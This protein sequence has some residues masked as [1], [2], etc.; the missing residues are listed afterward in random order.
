MQKRIDKEPDDKQPLNTTFFSLPTSSKASTKKTFTLDLKSIIEEK[1][2]S[3]WHGRVGAY[4]D[5]KFQLLSE[6]KFTGREKRIPFKTYFISLVEIINS[7]QR[8]KYQLMKNMVR[9]ISEVYGSVAISPIQHNEFCNELL[10]QIDI[11]M[12]ASTEKFNQLHSN[13]D[14]FVKKPPIDIISQYWI[15]LL[16]K[17]NP[18]QEQAKAYTTQLNQLIIWFEQVILAKEKS[19]QIMTHFNSR[20][21]ESEPCVPWYYIE[22]LFDSN[23]LDEHKLETFKKDYQ[24]TC[25]G[26]ASEFVYLPDMWEF[27]L[28]TNRHMINSSKDTLMEIDRILKKQTGLL[29]CKTQEQN[30]LITSIMGFI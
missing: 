18:E 20:T 10:F 14:R 16:S 30:K 23:K 27:V 11:A 21:F 8:T 29:E 17:F 24:Q 9:I 1:A 25:F 26:L 15:N 19:D 28:H 6:T 4:D 2:S 13:I 3:E 22:V 7:A 5:E 12:C